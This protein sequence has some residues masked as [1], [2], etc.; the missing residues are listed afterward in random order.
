[1]ALT[2]NIKGILHGM[3]NEQR[4]GEYSKVTWDD[5][6]TCSLPGLTAS[7]T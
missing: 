2:I 5:K 7:I 6:Q 1:M 3:R 4:G